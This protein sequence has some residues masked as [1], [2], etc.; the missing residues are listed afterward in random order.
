[1]AFFAVYFLWSLPA[2]AENDKKFAY[3]GGNIKF[4]IPTLFDK[5]HI[6]KQSEPYTCKY[7]LTLK[8]KAGDKAIR[9]A[10]SR[11]YMGENEAKSDEYLEQFKRD[12]PQRLHYIISYKTPNGIATIITFYWLDKNGQLKLIE[13][14]LFFGKEDAMSASAGYIANPNNANDILFMNALEQLFLSAEIDC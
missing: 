9:I 4:Y 10:F 5:K 11:A 12:Y 14:N 13:K 2:L 3:C 1:M 8:N 7:G 6:E